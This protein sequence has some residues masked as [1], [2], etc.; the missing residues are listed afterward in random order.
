MGKHNR[1]TFAETVAELGSESVGTQEIPAADVVAEPVRTRAP[2]GSLPPKIYTR[3]S[4]AAAVDKILS[5]LTEADRA[6][7]LAFVS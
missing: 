4:A 2:R 3:S 6:A 1:D 5:G 7:V